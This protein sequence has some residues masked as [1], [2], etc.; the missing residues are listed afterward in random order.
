MCE[1]GLD[2][3]G[4]ALDHADEERRRLLN[5]VSEKWLLRRNQ[6][7]ACFEAV[8]SLESV[9]LVF[10]VNIERC[11]R[12]AAATRLRG[13]RNFRRDSLRTFM[14]QTPRDFWVWWIGTLDALACRVAPWLTRRRAGFTLVL[15]GSNAVIVL[16]NGTAHGG[17]DAFAVNELD[18]RLARLSSEGDVRARC[19]VIRLGQSRY[20]LRPLSRL[21]LPA[22]RL[23]AAAALDLGVSTPFKADQVRILPVSGAAQASTYAIVK[24][25][26]LDQALTA[27]RKSA[28]SVASIEFETPNGIATLTP[29]AESVLQK[30]SDDWRKRLALASCAATALA[31]CATFAHVWVRNKVALADISK[32]VEVVTADAKIARKALDQRAQ[33]LAEL[34]ALRKN[35]EDTEPVTG[36]WEELARV[37]PDSAYLTD[38]SVKGGEVSVS[39]YASQAAALVVALEQS[40]LFSKAEFTAPVI[41]TPGIEGERFQIS[42]AAGG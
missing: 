36:V 37:L 33:S 16:D 32:L 2:F 8:I 28:I 7:P 17:G 18:E 12:I 10:S 23:A 21:S 20:V 38:L 42:L 19:G 5:E 24:H 27:F 6:I 40:P 35:I 4:K 15:S 31:L 39:G 30:R 9:L 22:S 26:I 14:V 1:N 13:R 34:T 25:A 11:I 3:A 41:K 29:G